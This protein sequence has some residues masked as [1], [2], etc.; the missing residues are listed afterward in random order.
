MHVCVNAESG[1]G[2]DGRWVEG[3][4]GGGGMWGVAIGIGGL[5]VGIYL[6]YIFKCFESRVVYVY[7]PVIIWRF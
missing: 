1:L 6:K 2:C 7:L 5:G 3:V 4:G